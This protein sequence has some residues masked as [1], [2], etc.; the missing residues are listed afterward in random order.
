MQLRLF[1]PHWL[2]LPSGDPSLV[3]L[4]SFCQAPFLQIGYQNV[5]C[6]LAMPF[7]LIADRS[8]TG[9]DAAQTDRAGP[10]TAS[11]VVS[12]GGWHVTA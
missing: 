9:P 3:A 10:E 6:W 11:F 2:V 8:E 7:N 5:N 4:L 12:D 1:G